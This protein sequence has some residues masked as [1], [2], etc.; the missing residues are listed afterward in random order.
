[1]ADTAN[2]R[3]QE[4]KKLPRWEQPTVTL[5]WPVIMRRKAHTALPSTREEGRGKAIVR[6]EKGFDKQQL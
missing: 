5:F 4:P 2:R 6:D 1:V 3:A